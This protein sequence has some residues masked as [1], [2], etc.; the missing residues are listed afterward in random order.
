[1]GQARFGRDSEQEKN[2]WEGQPGRAVGTV[3]LAWMTGGTWPYEVSWGPWPGTGGELARRSPDT[4][5]CTYRLLKCDVP[6][7]ARV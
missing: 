3:D 5:L 4:Y 6:H 7:T 1:M 2:N